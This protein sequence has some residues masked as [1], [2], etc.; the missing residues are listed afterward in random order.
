MENTET[1]TVGE[2]IGRLSYPFYHIGLY[3]K[4]SY[5]IRDVGLCDLLTETF[6]VGINT[7]SEDS[8]SS[9]EYVSI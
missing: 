8:L 9:I 1:I 7:S 3:M 6:K 4:V 2:T 5:S